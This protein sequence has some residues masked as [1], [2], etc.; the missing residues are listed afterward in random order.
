MS[1]TDRTPW[2]P[3]TLLTN[4]YYNVYINSEALQFEPITLRARYMAVVQLTD[5][6]IIGMTRNPSEEGFR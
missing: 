6:I 3:G 5:E 2:K 4:E 1:H